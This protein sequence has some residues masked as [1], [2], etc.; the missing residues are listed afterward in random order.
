MNQNSVTFL[1]NIWVY[2]N[3]ENRSVFVKATFLT[4]LASIVSLSSVRYT[5]GVII[6]IYC[7]SKAVHSDKRAA[8]YIILSVVLGESAGRWAYIASKRGQNEIMTVPEL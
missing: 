2:T 6:F 4:S 7:F 8:V 1:P 3:L 5:M